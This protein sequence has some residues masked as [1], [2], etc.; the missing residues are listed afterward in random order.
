[1]WEGS[2]HGFLLVLASLFG[3]IACCFVGLIGR[4]V[5]GNGAGKLFRRIAYRGRRVVWWWTVVAAAV[6]HM[7]SFVH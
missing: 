1:L 4:L 3:R 7:A 2:L 6:G 5:L